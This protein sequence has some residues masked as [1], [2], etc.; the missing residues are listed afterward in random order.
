MKRQIVCLVTICGVV[1]IG[2]CLAFYNGA[3]AKAQTPA[4]ERPFLLHLLT[5]ANKNDANA[6]VAFNLAWVAIEQGHPVEMLFDGW[7]SYNIKTSDFWAKYRVPDHFRKLVSET[8][9]HDV[10]WAGGTYMDLLKYLNGKGLV[11]AANKTFLALSRDDKKLPSFVQQWTLAE[12][13]TH[14]RNAGGY[15]SY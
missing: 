12:M 15:A 7:A 6:C 3:S 10:E 5:D 13:V 11:V 1:S 9:G 8:A 2:T 14:L 4:A